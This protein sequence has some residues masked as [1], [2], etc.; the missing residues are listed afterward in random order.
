MSRSRPDATPSFVLVAALGPPG[1]TLTLDQAESRYVARV[2]RAREGETLAATDGRGA[3][4]RATIL[5][6][7]PYVTVRIDS[8]DRAHAARAATIWCGAPEGSRADWLV[9]KLAELGVSCLQPIDCARAAWEGGAARLARY[10]RLAEAALRQSRRT[11][12]MQIETPRPL[13]D[14]IGT[15]PAGQLWLAD[16]DGDRNAIPASDGLSI[17]AVGPAEGFDAGERDSLVAAGFRPISLSD[18]RLRTETAAV[19]WA[20]WWSSHRP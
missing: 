4:A 7:R 20:S 14:M 18:G 12:L 16:P 15:A 6:T 11:R 9:E 8:L 3:L 13:A 10:R 19:S 1:A 2:C 5:A 17:V